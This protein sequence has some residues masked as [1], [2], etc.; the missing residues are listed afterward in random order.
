MVMMVVVMMVNGGKSRAGKHH[1]EQG[2]GKNL[3]HG[4]NV[5]RC[6]PQR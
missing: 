6:R 3:L 5:A 1:Q 2:S 4:M